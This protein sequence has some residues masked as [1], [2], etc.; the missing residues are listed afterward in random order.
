MRPMWLVLTVVMTLGSGC[1]M[2]PPENVDNA[3]AIFDQRGGLFNN[4]QR[5]A[6]NTEK[7]F[8]V[9]VPILMATIYQ[10]SRFQPRARP[11]R[12]KLLGFI[13]WRR[14]SNAFGY[15]Q[16][17]NSTWDWYQEATGKSFARRSKFKD[18]VHF[19]GWYHD[20]SHRRNG[21]AKTD[22]YNLYLAYYAGHGG[23]ARG[24]YR[25]N[26]GMLNSAARVASMAQTYDSQLRGCG[27]R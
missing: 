18:A 27:R 14:P 22:A 15:P 23:Y 3:C 1:A 21:I 6:K 4:W 12:T 10:E 8:G 25:N 5:Y 7:E 2:S 17:L 13:P 26:R 11:P 24:T 16:A 19:V 9:P 20:Q